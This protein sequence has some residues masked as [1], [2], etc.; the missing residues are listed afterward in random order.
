MFG[1][2]FKPHCHNLSHFVQN[3]SKTCVILSLCPFLTMLKGVL[4][5]CT[6]YVGGVLL[7]H[8]FFVFSL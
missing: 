4:F 6:K 8:V 5:F 7:Y 2:M 3:R 1:Y